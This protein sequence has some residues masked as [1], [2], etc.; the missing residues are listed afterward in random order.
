L[1]VTFRALVPWLVLAR[2]PE[3]ALSGVLQYNVRYAPTWTA[4]TTGGRLD[5]VRLD[6]LTNGWIVGPRNAGSTVIVIEVASACEALAQA[7]ALMLIVAAL[8]AT[9]R[10]ARRGIHLEVSHGARAAEV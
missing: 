8:L 6:A 3:S 1:P 2:L 10:D 4:L 5:H 7:A 9:L